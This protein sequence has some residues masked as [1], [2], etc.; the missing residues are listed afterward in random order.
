ML[1]LLQ[2]QPELDLTIKTAVPALGMPAEA[3]QVALANLAAHGLLVLRGNPPAFRYAP[4]SKEL[5]DAAELLRS[6][7]RKDRFAIVQLMSTNAMDRVRAAAL[8]RLGGAL[9]LRDSKKRR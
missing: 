1:L 5:G 8:D 7:Y 9:Q 6:A 4:T 3:C 2:G